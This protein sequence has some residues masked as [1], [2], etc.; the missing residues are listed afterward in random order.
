MFRPIAK[1]ADIDHE[2]LDSRTLMAR[3]ESDHNSV[4]IKRQRD[5]Y[6]GDDNS[7]EPAKKCGAVHK[8]QFLAGKTCC[9]Q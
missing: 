6:S 9:E 1:P 8:L 7:D 5:H 2:I 3:H 4:P